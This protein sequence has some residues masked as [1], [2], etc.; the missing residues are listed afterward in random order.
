MHVN[1]VKFP[2]MNI[3]IID[4]VMCYGDQSKTIIGGATESTNINLDCLSCKEAQLCP[5]GTNICFRLAAEYVYVFQGGYT[6][7]PPIPLPQECQPLR[8]V[9]VESGYEYI[10]Q[11]TS[12]SPHYK[13]ARIHI[14]LNEAESEFVID[15]GIVEENAVQTFAPVADNNVLIIDEHFVLHIISFLAESNSVLIHDAVHITMPIP[16]CNTITRLTAGPVIDSNLQLI[17]DCNVTDGTFARKRVLIA[18]NF[19][20]PPSVEDLPGTHLLN[21]VVSFSPDGDYIL[22]VSIT[23][24]TITQVNE[25]TRVPGI[26]TYNGPIAQTL[27]MTNTPLLVSVPGEK[28]EI[29]DIP[30][31]FS[32]SFEEGQ[33]VL[34]DSEAVCPQGECPPAV[35]NNGTLFLFTA[36]HSYQLLSAYDVSNPSASPK[37]INRV[38]RTTVYD[39]CYPVTA[40]ISVLDPLTPPPPPPPTTTPPTLT[41]TVKTGGI[42]GSSRS[43]FLIRDLPGIIIGSIIGIIGA[44]AIVAGIISVCCF[45]KTRSKNKNKKFTQETNSQ[46]QITISP[47]AAS[48]TLFSHPQQHLIPGSAVTS[49]YPSSAPS[50][51]YLDTAVAQSE[52]TTKHHSIPPQQ[53]LE[54]GAIKLAQMVVT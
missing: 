18:D 19:R 40:D 27:F 15:G 41:T 3:I 13:P 1:Y 21:D 37:R 23:Q 33:Y 47:I 46:I 11:C 44:I 25:L 32:S 49:S 2:S 9:E 53:L 43:H 48:N 39:A 50:L 31:L 29:I 26:L 42:S 35:Y 5:Q 36:D 4:S 17:V 7:Q 38:L 22:S 28:R 24:L 52:T 54:K 45:I 6:S 30:R 10:V 16:E 14:V 51:E 34:P 20:T 12:T 8:I